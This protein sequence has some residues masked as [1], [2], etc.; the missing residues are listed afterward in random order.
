MDVDA[1]GSD[2]H[3]GPVSIQEQS[4]NQVSDLEPAPSPDPW[5]GWARLMDRA[6]K[7]AE[8][9]P[10]SEPEPHP[11]APVSANEDL[12]KA[13]SQL[14]AE[15][16]DERRRRSDSEMA[17][18]KA[19]ERLHAA[20]MKAVEVAAEVQA[21]R[22]RIG[23]LERDRDEVIRRAEE[24]LTAVRERADQRL[25][26]E[27]DAAGRHWSELLDEERRR[28]EALDSE[29][30]A[31]LTRL[32]DAWLA[33]AVLRRSRPLRPRAYGADPETVEEAEQQVLEVL[34][35][36]EVDPAF[37]A[38]SPELASEIEHLRTR[39]RSRLHK[40]PEIDA[41]EDGVDQ[42]REARLARDAA[43]K[44]RRRK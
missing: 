21:A 26:S 23:E 19:D 16:A 27:L 43:P 18:A 10:E 42:L 34:E 11:E 15:L 32:E 29:R 39:L 14:A 35:E 44:N 5:S 31:L 36:H 8:P 41:V 25:A 22:A 9:E 20:E 24:L 28:V 37:A 13:V 1:R 4:L 30:T 12:V 7:Q 17:R 6:A 33:V 38:E 2:D 40:P 3:S